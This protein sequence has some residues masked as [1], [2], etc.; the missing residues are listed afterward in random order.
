MKK[1]YLSLT[2]LAAT[3]VISG[4]CYK[5]DNARMMAWGSN[6][7]VTVKNPD[8]TREYYETNGKPKSEGNS[9]GYYFLDRETGKIVEVS[10]SVTIKQK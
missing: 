3:V 4:G 5:A 9:D 7:S 8:G 10:G 1:L 6:W 2:I